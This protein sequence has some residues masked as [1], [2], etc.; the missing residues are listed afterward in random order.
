MYTANPRRRKIDWYPSRSSGVDSQV[1]PVCPPPCHRTSGKGRAFYRF[2]LPLDLA[3]KQVMHR[4][5]ALFEPRVGHFLVAALLIEHREDVLAIES[6]SLAAFYSLVDDAEYNQAVIDAR[7]K[8]VEWLGAIGYHHQSVMNALMR[9]GTIIPLRAFTL[10]ATPDRL[11]AH[12]DDDRDA[13]EKI[14]GRHLDPRREDRLAGG[15]AADRGAAP[16]QPAGRIDCKALVLVGGK[17]P[18]PGRNFAAQDAVGGGQEGAHRGAL[19]RIGHEAEPV[20]AA[21]IAALHP[22]RALRVCAGA[23]GTEDR[24]H[25]T[26]GHVGAATEHHTRREIT[27]LEP[28]ATREEQLPG[29]PVAAARGE[30]QRLHFVNFPTAILSMHPCST[31]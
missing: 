2:A 31:F 1:L 24:H 15:E 18:R 9:G 13:F 5:R 20:E 29:T 17:L 23:P 26:A 6:G 28:G 11:R 7:S 12:L 10:F 4:L 16:Q 27:R 22:H 21:E 30:N 3:M 14:L 19:E 25:G 8:D